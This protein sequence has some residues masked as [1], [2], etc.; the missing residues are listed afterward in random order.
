[1]LSD[2]QVINVFKALADQNRLHVFELLL[3]SDRTNSELM[4]E[5][6]LRQNLLSHHLNILNEAGL[7]Q[8][9]QSVGDARRHYYSANLNM[10]NAFGGWWKQLM[11]PKDAQLPALKQPRRVLFLC[12]RNLSR[13]LIAETLA[14]HFAANAL[15]VMSAGL[16]ACDDPLPPLMLQVLGENHVPAGGLT[17]KTVDQLDAAQHYDYL[18][19]VCDIVHENSIPKTLSYTE[20]VHWSLRDPIEDTNHPDEQLQ[21]MRELYD[22]VYQRLAL[23]VKRLA[24][25]EARAAEK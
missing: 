14:R 25:E 1:M 3:C 8:M 18:V 9:N 2:D 15:I 24:A 11:P 13:S 19:T 16:E 22:D 10:V 4:E 21:L 12:L 20:Y 5:T 7:I 23:M 17:I 6:G